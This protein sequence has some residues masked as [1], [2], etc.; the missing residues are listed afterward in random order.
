MDYDKIE[1]DV[2]M[3]FREFI[4]KGI[5]DQSL[6]EEHAFAIRAIEDFMDY[7]RGYPLPK[8]AKFRF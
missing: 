2:K 1:E 3:C 4:N 5:I 8:C 6:D 7:V